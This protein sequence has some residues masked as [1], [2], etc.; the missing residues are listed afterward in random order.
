MKKIIWTPILSAELNDV[1]SGDNS[2]LPQLAKQFKTTVPSIRG[3][4]V[5]MGIF[6]SEVK[7]EVSTGSRTS[8]AQSVSAV[9]TLLSV[10]AG[11]L[12]TMESMSV[13]QLNTLTNR[14]IQQSE[15]V[16]LTVS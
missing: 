5:S 13:A 2:I 4:L 15:Q 8:K 16:N 10:P 11:S 1:Y 12:S 6:V 14:L 3:K 7:K 9:E